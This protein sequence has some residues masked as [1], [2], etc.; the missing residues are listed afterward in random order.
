MPGFQPLAVHIKVLYGIN[1]QP[2]NNNHKM[3][4]PQ[5]VRW[6]DASKQCAQY[7]VIENGQ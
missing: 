6:S 5:L 4:V 3:C 7:I 2:Q 1:K